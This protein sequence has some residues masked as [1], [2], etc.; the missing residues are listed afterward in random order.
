MI[1][2]LLY[3]ALIGAVVV[4]GYQL[5]RVV[6]KMIVHATRRMPKRQRSQAKR[7]NPSDGVLYRG[8]DLGVTYPRDEF[9]YA[10][11]ERPTYLRVQAAA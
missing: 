7:R 4:F 5:M 3:A 11:Y 6:L 10:A 1:S 2:L 9:D 8:S